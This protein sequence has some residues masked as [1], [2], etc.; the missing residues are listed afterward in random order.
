M[1]PLAVEAVRVAGQLA[2]AGVL[3]LPGAESIAGLCDA[4]ARTGPGYVS[5]SGI[6]PFG[7]AIV[8]TCCQDE[9]VGGVEAVRGIG[10]QHAHAVLTALDVLDDENLGA[11]R[12]EGVEDVMDI[13]VHA[14]DGTVVLAK[15][16]KVRGEGYSW[17]K[18]AL[19]DVM[20]MWA[21]LDVAAG[22]SFE[23]LT[24][25]RLG[26]SGMEVSAALEAAADGSFG[27]LA[28]LLD[29]AESSPICEILSRARVLQ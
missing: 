11:I 19:L 3:G 22:A 9:R 13:E 5:V 23:F 14:L 29:E 15:Q 2:A 16:V 1:R 4:A 12:V 28:A 27:Q 10:Y 7:R 25:G 8:G 21:D 24:D 17:G 26:P 20:R 6:W 18:K